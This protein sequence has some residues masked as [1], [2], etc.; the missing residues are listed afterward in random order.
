MANNNSYN[1]YEKLNQLSN[2]EDK[3]FLLLKNN[4]KEVIKK[5]ESFNI[6][7]TKNII[8]DEVKKQTKES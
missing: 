6:D 8:L 7:K 1:F 4:C 5:V 2:S 3:D